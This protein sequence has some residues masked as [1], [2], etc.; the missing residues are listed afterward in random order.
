MLVKDINFT[1]CVPTPISTNVDGTVFFTLDDFDGNAQS[2]WK[3][4]APP[5]ARSKSSTDW[6]TIW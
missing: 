3:P 1:F 2:L 4:M 5:P 6:Q